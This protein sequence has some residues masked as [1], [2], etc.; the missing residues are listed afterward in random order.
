M[1]TK[2]ELSQ[3]ERDELVRDSVGLIEI[4]DEALESVSGGCGGPYGCGGTGGGFGPST[5]SWSC[6]PPGCQ[7]P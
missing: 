3:E 5:A 6:M 2:I 7:C 4:E 1:S